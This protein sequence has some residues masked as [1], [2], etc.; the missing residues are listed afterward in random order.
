MKLKIAWGLVV[1]CLGWASWLRAG[2]DLVIEAREF[3]AADGSQ[4]LYRLL[5]PPGF[6]MHD[7]SRSYPLLIFL[8]G[9]GERGDDNKAQLKWGREFMEMVAREH[10]CVVL[11]PQCPSGQKWV[12]VD[13]S[14][15]DHRLPDKPSQ[16]MQALLE[17]L[18]N[19]A[20]KLR[21]DPD[22]FYV[23]GLSM[24][25]YGTWGMIQRDP[26]RFAAAVPICG[27]GDV[28]RAEAI[29]DVP[30]WCFH[31]SDDRAVPVERSRMMID[32]MRK[33]GGEPKYTEYDGVGHNSWSPAFKEPELPKWLFAQRRGQ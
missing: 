9:A 10:D 13:W 28:S 8:H 16:P 18:P 21:L 30:V 2:E 7:E 32:A 19:L 24:G 29:K 22:R 31:G 25:G 6:D 26:K 14:A 33:A 12:D 17:L 27:G 11:V 5:L 23:M 1:L 3:V 4:F 20:K 15:R